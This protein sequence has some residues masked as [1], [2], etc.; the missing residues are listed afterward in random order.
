LRLLFGASYAGR[1]GLLVLLMSVGLAAYL[2]SVL[3]FALTAARTFTVQLPVFA[4]TTLACA[5]GCLWL[6]P[7]QGLPGAAAAWG[8]SMLLEAG[9][10][11]A[12][13]SRALRRRAQRGTP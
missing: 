6:V 12:L 2:S 1:S 5:A 11:A 9:A 13:L 8:A 3:G 4:A 10:V 7:R